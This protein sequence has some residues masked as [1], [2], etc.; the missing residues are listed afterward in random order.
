MMCFQTMK[1]PQLLPCGHSICKECIP[2]CVELREAL[3][4]SDRKEARRLIRVLTG[5]ATEE[6]KKV[7]TAPESL[8]CPFCGQECERSKITPNVQL[9]SIIASNAFTKQFAQSGGEKAASVC[10][11]CGKPASKFCCF[12]GPLCDEHNTFLHTKGPLGSHEVSDVP[13]QLLRSPADVKGVVVGRRGG[14][15]VDVPVCR[16]HNASMELFCAD[17]QQLV[18]H[19]C[20]VSETN[21]KG[22]KI[23]SLDQAMKVSCKKVGELVKSIETGL[24][25]WDPAS[26]CP[27]PEELS[28]DAEKE[29]ILK[30]IKE[31]FDGLRAVVEENEKKSCE[32]VE[33][34]YNTFHDVMEKRLAGA[35]FMKKESLRLL[36]SQSLS[37]RKPRPTLR[38][39]S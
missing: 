37:A 21:H 28:R 38:A 27:K 8:S 34:T 6:E 30:S 32:R 26:V 11:F 36:R 16:S 23:M 12:C 3:R 7:D 4:S 18:C 2:R 39:P 33:E 17:C 10:G 15:D 35:Q 13:V 31:F 22:H 24:E 20:A 25:K 5:N 29:A 1:D 14:Q 9:R 19:I